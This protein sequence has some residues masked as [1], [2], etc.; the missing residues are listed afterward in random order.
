MSLWVTVLY[1]NIMLP[2]NPTTKK[3]GNKKKSKNR[4]QHLVKCKL[5]LWS[6]FILHMLETCIYFSS[7]VR[8]YVYQC[9]L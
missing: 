3:G 7:D 6:F 1:T 2:P 5:T 4:K 9:Y 8:K